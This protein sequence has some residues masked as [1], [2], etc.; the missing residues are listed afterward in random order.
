MPTVNI[1]LSEN[2]VQAGNRAWDD[3]ISKFRE[4][5]AKQLSCSERQLKSNE[6]SIRL[7]MARGVDMIAPIEIDITAHAYAERVQRSDEICIAIR[8][9]VLSSIPKANDVRVCYHW[10]N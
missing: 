9:I 4:L 7:L 8:S 2:H 5:I 1:Y 3:N 6:V 10:L